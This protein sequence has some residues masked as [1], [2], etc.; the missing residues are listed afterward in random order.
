MTDR[1]VSDPETRTSWSS[2]RPSTRRALLRRGAVAVGTGMI[3]GCVRTRPPREGASEPVIIGHRGC[4]AENPENTIEAIE[5]AAGVADAV[6]LDLRRC[7]TGEI[8]VFH[9]E[10]LDRL[11]TERGRVDET[12]CRTVTELE[13]DDSGQ[14]I[15]TLREAFDATPSDVPL[16]L[17][18]KESGLVEDVLSIHAEYDHEVLLSSFRPDVIAEVRAAD[19]TVPTALIV[20][21]SRPNRALRPL[22]PG[23]P[24]VAYLPENVTELVDRAVKSGCEAIH[25]RYELCLRTDLVER[26]HAAGLRVEAWTV[27]TDEEFEALRTAGVDA[28][29]SDVCVT[30][31]GD[32]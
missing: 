32:G 22:I 5:A 1:A 10:A 12:S 24:S 11:T 17:D 21:E 28:V 20:R 14:R 9:D 31:S 7:G 25:P 23:L 13:V 18:L 4:A 19:P 27:T 6:E 16:V 30:L 3:A 26:A 15:P 8:V 29:I 2:K